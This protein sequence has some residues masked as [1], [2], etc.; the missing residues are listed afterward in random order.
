M[1]ILGG[2]PSVH[3]NILEGSLSIPMNVHGERGGGG[4]GGGVIQVY[5]Y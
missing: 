5:T 2:N 4:G 3:V 1:I